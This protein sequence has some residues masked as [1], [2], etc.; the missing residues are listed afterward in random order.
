MSFC[1][2]SGDDPDRVLC[3]FDKNNHHHGIVEQPDADDPVLAIV[4]SSV[5]QSFPVGGRSYGLY[6]RDCKRIAV[7][8]IHAKRIEHLMFGLLVLIGDSN[9]LLGVESQTLNEHMK[10]IGVQRSLLMPFAF[11]TTPD[12]DL[13]DRRA[14]EDI[15][16]PAQG[17]YRF[18]RD[19]R[20]S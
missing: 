10:E 3:L 11:G 1:L 16:L 13:F 19:F 12:R 14:T 17:V 2:S 5:F 4:L 20:L 15:K 9:T 8:E 18:H 7:I 6:S